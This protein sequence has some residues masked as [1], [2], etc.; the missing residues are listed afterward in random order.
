MYPN[1]PGSAR[2]LPQQRLDDASPGLGNV[3]PIIPTATQSQYPTVAQLIC[4]SAQVARRARMRCGRKMQVGQRVTAEAVGATLQEQKLRRKACDMRQHCGPYLKKLRVP[5]TGRQRHI[6]L[7]TR[8]RA[9]A[10]FTLGTCARVERIATLMQI[11]N[12]D[13]RVILECIEYAVPVVGI[14]IHIGDAPKTMTPTQ[15]F[16]DDTAI[17]EDAKA[18]RAI[19]SGVMKSGDRHKCAASLARHD[20][21]RS[22]QTRAHNAGGRFVDTTE[23]RSITAIEHAVSQLGAALHELDM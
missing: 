12:D 6:E 8:T 13:L 2:P 15:G 4:K 23:I 20:P 1:R 19:A 3:P 14:D 17:V 9:A 5:G 22:Q 21:I 7:G 18:G 16:N 11:G 10:N